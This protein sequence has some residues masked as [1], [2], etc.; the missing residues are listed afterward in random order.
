MSLFSTCLIPSEERLDTTTKLD[1]NPYASGLGPL[2]AVSASDSS[3]TFIT[4]HAS[5]EAS[6]YALDS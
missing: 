1:C 4:P 5:L 2:G 3:P 6:T